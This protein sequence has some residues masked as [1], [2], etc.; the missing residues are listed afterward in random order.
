[1]PG[2]DDVSDIMRRLDQSFDLEVYLHNPFSWNSWANGD[3]GSFAGGVGTCRYIVT[4]RY[5]SRAMPPFL[6]QGANQVL[7][8]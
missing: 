6:G 3:I 5:E 2:K 1:M 4:T 8:E 7:Q